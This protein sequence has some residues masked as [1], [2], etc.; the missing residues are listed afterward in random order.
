MT[1]KPALSEMLK[2]ILSMERKAISRRKIGSTKAVKLSISIKISPGIHKM[3][4]CKV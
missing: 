3:K 1:T 2:G 4:G